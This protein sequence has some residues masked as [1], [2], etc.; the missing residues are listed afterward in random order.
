MDRTEPKVS[1]RFRRRPTSEKQKTTITSLWILHGMRGRNRFLRTVPKS[2]LGNCGAQRG[3]WRQTSAPASPTVTAPACR[4]HFSSRQE[5][6]FSDVAEIWGIKISRKVVPQ[7]APSPGSQE[8][9]GSIPMR[10]QSV[11]C[12][13]WLQVFSTAARL[14]PCV[15]LR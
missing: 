6:L 12:S 7:L 15:A 13:H 10:G 5:A 4:I 14:S 2:V 9:V 3:C 8:V 11:W 1:S